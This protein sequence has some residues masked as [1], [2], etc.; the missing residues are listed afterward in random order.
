MSKIIITFI[1]VVCAAGCVFAWVMGSDTWAAAEAVR[2]NIKESFEEL[3]GK[4]EIKIAKIN[5][6]IDECNSK[7]SSLVRQEASAIVEYEYASSRLKKIEKDLEESKKSV[8]KVA[9][10]IEKGDGVT[11]RDG[12]EL[13][14]NDLINQAEV[15]K[16]RHGIIKQRYETTKK[17]IDTYK[18]LSDKSNRDRISGQY[19][20]KLLREKRDLLLAKVDS[21]KAL[22]EVQADEDDYR[23]VYQEASDLLD[24][25]TI[26]I[27]KEILFHEKMVEISNDQ[28]TIDAEINNLSND[29]EEIAADLRSIVE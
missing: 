26:E 25:V 21:L 6:V 27:D 10:L 1:L 20:V 13:S 17:I 14:H 19:N 5:Q 16:T 18:G 11:L 7:T 23:T 3:I 4:Y 28:T 12:R 22:K 8:L 2:G 15:M 29:S 9:D 24:S